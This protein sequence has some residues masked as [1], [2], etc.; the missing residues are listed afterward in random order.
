MSQKDR[1]PNG[2]R[3]NRACAA[4]TFTFNGR[5]YQ[6]YQGDTLA[7]ALLRERRAFRRA[8]LEVSPAARH[9][10]ARAWKSRMPSCNWKRARTRC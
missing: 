1:L 7:S 5:Q 3:I 9:R 10:D 8:E 4:L 2:G 6:G